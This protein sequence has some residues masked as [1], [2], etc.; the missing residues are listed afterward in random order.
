MVFVLA[1]TTGLHCAKLFA[2]RLND[3]DFRAG[4]IRVGKSV[5]QRTCKIGP[6]KNAAAGSVSRDQHSG[7]QFSRAL[8]VGID[9]AFHAGTLS[10]FFRMPAG[11]LVSFPGAE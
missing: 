7:P 1:A 5:D 11:M 4:A 3:V 10:A 9:S 8:L 6:C 2:L